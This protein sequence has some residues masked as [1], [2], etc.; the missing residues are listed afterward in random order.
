MIKKELAVGFSRAY[1][2]K[3]IPDTIRQI[4]LEWERGKEQIRKEYLG[5]FDEL[6]QK[7]IGL[8]KEGGKGRIKF[9]DIFYLHSSLL[10]E[11]YELQ[12]ELFDRNFYKD[13][14]PCFV[15]WKP[16]FFIRHFEEDL[17][18]FE[19]KAKNEI[20]QFDYSV[21]W[22]VKKRYYSMFLVMIGEFFR[23]EID[24]VREL[25]SYQE[26]YKEEDV[27]I[28]YGAYMDQGVQIWPV[29]EDA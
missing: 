13:S 24:H 29:L 20:I 6:F 25:I 26:L 27:R 8:Q 7:C 16:D 23:R 9:I 2:Q 1:F 3:T 5:I 14:Q 15:N 17:A 11:T 4:S 19:K 21:F 10:T 18:A 12:L 22:D 28:I